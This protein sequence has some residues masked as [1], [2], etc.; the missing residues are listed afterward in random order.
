MASGKRCL[1]TPCEYLG[2][3]RVSVEKACWGIYTQ[4]LRGSPWHRA[5][6]LCGRVIGHSRDVGVCAVL[7]YLTGVRDVGSPKISVFSHL[8]FEQYSIPEC[9]AATPRGFLIRKVFM[10]AQPRVW[11]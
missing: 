6:A 11:Y 9:G 2:L 3:K 10:V 8:P 4:P 5:E 1:W 7:A